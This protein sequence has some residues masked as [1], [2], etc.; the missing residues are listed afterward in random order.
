MKKRTLAIVLCVLLALIV[1][2]AIIG[3]VLKINLTPLIL[4]EI[5]LFLIGCGLLDSNLTKY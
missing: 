4:S 1:L 2:T 3:G 5:G